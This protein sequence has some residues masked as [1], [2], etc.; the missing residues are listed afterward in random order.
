VEAVAEEMRGWALTAGGGDSSPLAGRRTRSEPQGASE[1]AAAEAE[2]IDD[3]PLVLDPAVVHAS[4]KHATPTMHTIHPKDLERL[5]AV[6]Q[7]N[8]HEVHAEFRR[9][10]RR[11][12]SSW[13]ARDNAPT[14]QGKSGPAGAA[15]PSILPPV[16]GGKATLA[17]RPPSA[18]LERRSSGDRGTP[19]SG[20]K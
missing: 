4:V 8:I 5:A 19:S 14:I 20:K 16:V 7:Q 1:V 6:A 11:Q 18:A 9:R 13:G 10:Q 12:N 17:S 3:A 15:A 2:I